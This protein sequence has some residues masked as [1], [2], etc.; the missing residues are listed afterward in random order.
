MEMISRRRRS[1]AGS[2]AGFTLIEAMVTLA[3]LVILLSVAAPSFRAYT[4]GQRI[5]SAS[6]ELVFGLNYARSEAIARRTD[7][8][9]I[10]A[11]GGFANGW[12][13]ES[14]ATMLREQAALQGV[15]VNGASATTLTYGLDGRTG[16]AFNAMIE[17]PS[18]G[19]S[20]EKRCVSIDAMGMP[21]SR[22]TTAST[23]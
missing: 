2:G 19:V 1:H 16:T 14:G 10:A 4:E 21:R 17:A 11:T 13:I 3:V 20:T 8:T 15:A 12:T 9:L 7:V 5:K 18:G 6:Q 22:K 23:C